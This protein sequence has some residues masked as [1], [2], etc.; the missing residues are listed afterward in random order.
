[1]GNPKSEIRNP[2]SEIRNPKSEIDKLISSDGEL[3]IE[4]IQ[5]LCV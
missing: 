5:Q 3:K 1:M 2:K 4:K